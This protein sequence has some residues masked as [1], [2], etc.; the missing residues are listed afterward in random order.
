MRTEREAFKTFVNE[1]RLAAA[2]Y[3][4]WESKHGFE[5]PSIFRCGVL[6]E[7][8]KVALSPM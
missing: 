3:Y 7:A 2:I 4:N 8:G 6:T 1:G 5:Y